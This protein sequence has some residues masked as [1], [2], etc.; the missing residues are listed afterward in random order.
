MT[1]SSKSI[2]ETLALSKAAASIGQLKK[3][4]WLWGLLFGGTAF[5]L[6]VLAAGWNVV[7]IRDYDKLTRTEA[8]RRFASFAVLVLEMLLGSLGFLVV[9]GLTIL[10]FIRLLKEMKLNLLQSEFLA[11]LSHELKTPLS[12]IELAAD[13]LQAGALSP[14]DSARL[15][16]NHRSELHR[17]RSQLESLLEAARWQSGVSPRRREIVELEQWIQALLTKWAPAYGPAGKLRREGDPLH[18]AYLEAD[19]DA[20]GL[21]GDNILLNAQKFAQGQPHLTVRTVREGGSFRVEFEDQGWGFLPEDEKK[22]FQRFYRAKAGAPY[23]I[24][25]SGLGLFLAKAASRANG[26]QLSARTKGLKCGAVFIL[27]GRFTHRSKNE[28]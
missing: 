28:G 7:L 15:W 14:E 3:R 8:P 10:L 4:R 6:V 13:L 24:A 27:E 20:L 26:L 23:A 12:S 16:S 9:M 1:A 22:I 11:S 18:E 21:I 25:G 5:L 17:L 2:S 19:P